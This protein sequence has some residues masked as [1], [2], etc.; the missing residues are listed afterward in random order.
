MVFW[1]GYRDIY[2]IIFIIHIINFIIWITKLLLS[3]QAIKFMVYFVIIVISLLTCKAIYN[4]NFI[5]LS[6]WE[7]INIAFVIKKQMFYHVIIIV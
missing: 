1:N 5:F 7:R 6:N 3:R 4:I 2:N